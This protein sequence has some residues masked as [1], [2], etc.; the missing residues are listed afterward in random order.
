MFAEVEV[1]IEIEVDMRERE[2]E[3]AGMVEMREPIGS[4]T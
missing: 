1:E 4:S 2:L 3:A